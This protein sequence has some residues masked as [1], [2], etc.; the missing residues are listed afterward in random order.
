VVTALLGSRHHH[1]HHDPHPHHYH[2]STQSSV[3]TD[4]EGEPP[5]A[6]RDAAES[7]APVDPNAVA[8]PCCSD[9]PVGDLER[10]HRMAEEMEQLTAAPVE[11]ATQQDVEEGETKLD[12]EGQ[13]PLTTNDNEE[14]NLVTAQQEADEA[15]RRKQIESQKLMRM[16]INTALAIGYVRV[17]F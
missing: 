8:C 13:A 16:S 17:T 10:V 5:V 1:H 6:V 15:S 12:V 7:S 2:H 3:P 9:D 14:N 11:P 4:Q